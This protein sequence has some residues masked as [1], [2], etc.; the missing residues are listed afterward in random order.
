MHRWPSQ[1]FLRGLLAISE[2]HRA[3]RFAR[4]HSR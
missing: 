2:L 4:I 1:Y 3:A